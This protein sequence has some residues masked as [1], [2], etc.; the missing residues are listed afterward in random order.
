MTFAL[1]FA[2]ALEGGPAPCVVT[3]LGREHVADL[4]AQQRE[5]ETQPTQTVNDRF[6]ETGVEGLR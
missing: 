1:G 5:R 4:A 2:P 6:S 3:G